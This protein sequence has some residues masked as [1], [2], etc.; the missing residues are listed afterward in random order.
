MRDARTGYQKSGAEMKFVDEAK[1]SESVSVFFR[2]R[3][4]FY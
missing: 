1:F 4:E 2:E 3:L